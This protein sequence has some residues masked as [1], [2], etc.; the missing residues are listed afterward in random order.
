MQMVDISEPFDMKVVENLTLGVRRDQ[1]G[2]SELL[3]AR[4]IVDGII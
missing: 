4:M 1:N 3:S 2:T